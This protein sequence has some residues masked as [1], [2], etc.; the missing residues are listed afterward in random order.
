MKNHYNLGER[1]SIDVD[2][3]PSFPFSTGT[4]K[5]I[6][7]DPIFP[8]IKGSV[9]TLTG[10]NETATT[11]GQTAMGAAAKVVVQGAQTIPVG[12]K[13]VASFKFSTALYAGL[14]ESDGSIEESSTGLNFTNLIDCATDSHFNSPQAP[15]YLPVN[16]VRGGAEVSIEMV[17]QPGGR[18]RLQRS[19][20]KRDR[21]NFLIAGRRETTFLCYL[22]VVLPSGKHVPV[23][24]FA[25]SDVQDVDINWRA[26]EPTIIRSSVGAKF[27]FRVLKLDSADTR[28]T[29]LSN[30]SLAT[31]DT[32][33]TKYNGAMFKAQAGQTN[34][35]YSIQQF[36][37]YGPAVTE[38]MKQRANQSFQLN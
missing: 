28:F 9:N 16:N 24:G 32:I 19:N 21:V 8:Q 14:K 3:T 33:V 36:D 13:Q 31:P 34:A 29:L 15:F 17:D 20:A 38:E 5:L 10:P 12:F 25:W 27:N 11:L 18:W 35:D 30:P 4:A 2:I 7:P 1:I 37:A 23:E 22:V 26:G 6:I